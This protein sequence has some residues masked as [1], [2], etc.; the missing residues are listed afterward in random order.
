M[1]QAT[2]ASGT[3]A[4]Q[5]LA[6]GYDGKTVIEHLD[7][8][9]DEGRIT[10]LIGPNACG[11]STL[12]A[13]MSRLL[14]LAHGTVVLDGRAIHE[15]PTREVARRLGIL[16]QS[17]VAPEGITVAELV[18]RG[19]HPHQRFGVR[20]ELDDEVVAHALVRT[21]VAD[22]ATRP[23]D[24]LSGGQR[25][26]A[27]IAM[28]IAQRTP[29]LLLDEPTTFLDIAHQF[30]VLDLL[31]D[32]NKDGTTIVLVVHDLN[33]AA[34]YAHRVV[35]MRDGRIV[36]AGTPRE[37]MTEETIHDVFGVAARVIDDPDTGSAHVIVRG[38]T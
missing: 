37:V 4:A 34:R 25:Q 17:P 1:T 20:T 32:L 19:R 38:A 18:Y 7:L 26:R 10:A 3:L 5:E 2:T 21:G 24:S 29:V 23:L 11:K 16:P 22:L 36:A 14:P 28:A 9:I 33:H 12:L 30:E 8:E 31:A 35:A 27:W 15:L 13:A 6:V